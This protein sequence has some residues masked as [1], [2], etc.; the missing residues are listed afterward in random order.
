MPIA[1]LSQN[2]VLRELDACDAIS[3]HLT[4]ARFL[5]EPAV[6]WH[7]PPMPCTSCTP[8]WPTPPDAACTSAH[9][10]P[11][12]LL[13]QAWDACPN[14]TA[15]VMNAVGRVLA[16]MNPS[17]AGL[18][19][20]SRASHATCVPRHPGARPST[21]VPAGRESECCADAPP[22]MTPAQSLP[23]APGSPGY[24]PSTLRTSR[25]LMPTA[26]T[27]SC[28]VSAL[29]P[30][31]GNTAALATRLLREPRGSGVICTGFSGVSH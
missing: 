6:P 22:T 3:M 16:S 17:A 28:W 25:K 20:T 21:A 12:L 9:M 14:A 30:S 11:A 10:L 26:R 24:I 27:R 1:R 7:H 5:T 19:A 31:C 29:M 15:T 8:A 4:T 23:G 18:G 2:A 13:P